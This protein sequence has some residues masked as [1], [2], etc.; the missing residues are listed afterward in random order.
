MKKQII[1]FL[2]IFFLIALP[3]VKGH[4]EEKEVKVIDVE[5]GDVVKTAPSTDYY[6]NELKKAIQSMKGITVKI[7]PLPKKDT[8][9]SFSL[10][11]LLK[12]K[13]S[14][15]MALYQKE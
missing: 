12:W 15:S 4:A 5:T 10:L 9:F 6:S 14:G 1:C 3:A 11:C 13:I 8:W 2:S 7:N